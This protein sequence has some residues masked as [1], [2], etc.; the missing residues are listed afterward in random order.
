MNLIIKEGKL[1]DTAT[2]QFIVPQIGN[3][4]HIEAVR[5]LENKIRLLE[6]EGVEVSVDCSTKSFEYDTQLKCI[7]GV[8]VSFYAESE[9]EDDFDCVVGK[10]RTCRCGLKYIVDKNEDDEVVV[11]YN[12]E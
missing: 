12:K 4:E 2:K 9:D 11:K 6:N 3:N 1:Y 10:K 5:K 8:W 7:C